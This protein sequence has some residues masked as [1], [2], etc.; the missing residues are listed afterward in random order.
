MWFR[1]ARAAEFSPESPGVEGEA[2]NGAHDQEGEEE[3]EDEVKHLQGAVNHGHGKTE[4]RLPSG[5]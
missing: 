3:T 4:Q 2:A 5:L 1:D